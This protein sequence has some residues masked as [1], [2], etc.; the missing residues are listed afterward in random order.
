MKRYEA[1]SDLNVKTLFD[2]YKSTLIELKIRR[3]NLINFDKTE[4][5]V[6]CSKN[7]DIIVFE[8]TKKFYSIY[9][10]NRK[11]V[12]IVEMINAVNN[13]FSSSLIIIQKQEIMIN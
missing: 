13:Y 2:D 6:E 1:V 4:V 8:N 5:H 12:T 11:S 9:F 3:R 10:E 7:E